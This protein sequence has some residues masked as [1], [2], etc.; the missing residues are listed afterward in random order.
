MVFSLKQ[1]ETSSVEFSADFDREE[2]LAAA[3]GNY[4]D[5]TRAS[6]EILSDIDM[7]QF[8]EPDEKTA[9]QM[10]Y[11]EK[12][13][14]FADRLARKQEECQAQIDKNQAVL[15][16]QKEK[17][18]AVDGLE[19]AKRD[20]ENVNADM[21][22]LVAA[23]P[24][25]MQSAARAALRAGMEKGEKAEMPAPRSI[26][27]KIQLFLNK[28]KIE[29]QQQDFDHS[30]K[31]AV[32][33]G[34]NGFVT[35][36]A[37]LDKQ[38][39]KAQAELKRA[40]DKV[41]TAEQ[42]VAT[43]QKKLDRESKQIRDESV[44][45][46][47]YDAGQLLYA[48][49]L[50]ADNALRAVKLP[51]VLGMQNLTEPVACAQAVVLDKP[52]QMQDLVDR[53]NK[54]GFKTVFADGADMDKVADPS[55]F[56]IRRST[57]GQDSSNKYELLT[58]FFEPDQARDNIV[59][60]LRVVQTTK[61][62][63]VAGAITPMTLGQMDQRVAD[64]DDKPRQLKE[65]VMNDPTV[66]NEDKVRYARMSGEEIRD[67][68]IAK[69]VEQAGR[70]GD[71]QAA[72]T[73]R[74]NKANENG[75]QYFFR[76]QSFIAGDEKSSYMN[77]TQRVGR[78]GYT[79]ASPNPGYAMMYSGAGNSTTGGSGDMGKKSVTFSDGTQEN[80]GFVSVYKASS[81]TLLTKNFGLEGMQNVAMDSTNQNGLKRQATWSDDLEA[82]MN[83][84]DN[85]L[86]AR[87]LV[88]P[89]GVVTIPEDDPKW[90]IICDMYAPDTKDSFKG[91]DK[92]AAYGAAYEKRLDALRAQQ[93]ANGGKVTT[94][95][96]SHEDLAAIWGTRAKLYAKAVAPEQKTQQPEEKAALRQQF[97]SI[98]TGGRAE[99]NTVTNGNV[100][101]PPPPRTDENAGAGKTGTLNKAFGNPRPQQ[102]QTAAARVSDTA[103][104]DDP[105]VMYALDGQGNRLFP[106]T[107]APGMSQENITQ[108]A[109]MINRACKSPT[110]RDTLQ[111]ASEMGHTFRLYNESDGRGGY[112]DNYRREI[113]MNMFNGNED[114][115]CSTLV[116][117]SRHS[118]QFDQIPQFTERFRDFAG[119]DFKS[120]TIVNRAIEA[121]AVAI[122]S[123]FNVEM[124]LAGDKGPYEAMRFHGT[125]NVSEFMMQAANQGKLNDPETLKQGAD[126]WYESAG[127]IN[128]YDNYYAGVE[129][130]RIQNGENRNSLTDEDLNVLTASLFNVR[131]R[132]YAGDSGEYLKTAQKTML[133]EKA[134]NDV[135]QANARCGKTDNSVD[136][137]PVFNE[138][139]G[140]AMEITHAERCRMDALAYLKMKGEPPKAVMPPPPPRT[141]VN[142]NVMPPPPP[143]TATN[144]TVMP[145][146]PPPRTATDSTVMPPPP[147]PR[148]ATNNTVMPPPPPRMAA[149]NTV[150][151]PP[152]PRTAT[153]NT[154]MPPPPPPRTATNN[155]VMP[156]PPP[157]TATDSTV[158]P[159]PPP[160]RT[161]TNNTVMPPPPPPRTA[162]NN[163]VMPPPPPR[164]AT[165]NTVM[166][167][168]PPRTA[169]DNTVM[170]PPP[171]HRADVNGNVMPPPLSS[172]QAKLTAMTRKP[173]LMQTLQNRTTQE[174]TAPQIS[175]R[176]MSQR[177]GEAR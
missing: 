111:Q 97:H 26:K 2:V 103:R 12:E 106:Y 57:H 123:K 145:P 136:S 54:A 21:D 38:I 65:C 33:K 66:S 69:A 144:N 24:S 8:F 63:Q 15:D 17:Q 174:Q 11:A 39:E 25:S 124:A 85:P 43:W 132:Q 55:V 100:M 64:K 176:Q 1:R 18:A 151:P 141:D 83:P 161:A 114:F 73:E 122:Q 93:S 138:F 56:V 80:I 75:A 99:T 16:D 31:K 9:L 125:K 91:N 62:A 72:V 155:T 37:A 74:L 88:S 120:S 77:P 127:L 22:A 169:T 131:G 95:G 101:P 170:P 19:R 142:G 168:P 128:Y 108:L 164:T 14:S 5:A 133:T 58:P 147:P 30:Q 165:D 28:K 27:E 13:R 44:A 162:T 89:R 94:Y 112:Y 7:D 175:V 86:A 53:M 107:L 49:E 110:G 163:T 150:M 35:N 23:Y 160:P 50:Y 6:R 104:A 143:R 158:M 87:L 41:P 126:K 47:Q 46:Y 177:T 105:N 166:P 116:H 96:R 4:T 98:L 109:G 173:N 79:Y 137:M 139:T 59:N 36:P 119:L 70:N 159:P 156:P 167:P 171:P 78:A 153:D 102:P 3:K 148:T 51:P 154:V 52:E 42:G 67:D 121:D 146:P 113:C 117:E 34:I 84:N 140:K 29:K 45:S 68:I 61:G 71:T 82:H 118:I 48:R 10:L 76:G 90:K 149:D 92:A 172:L 115:M 32:Q 20:V 129:Q 157:R 60:A 152:P 135:K 81:K 134:Y 40:N 130:G